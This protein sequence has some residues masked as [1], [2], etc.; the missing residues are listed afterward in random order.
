MEQSRDLGKD[1]R[2]KD[3]EDDINNYLEQG[4]KSGGK[5]I[6]GA[7]PVTRLLENGICSLCLC[8]LQ[9]AMSRTAL[10]LVF[11]PKPNPT[12]SEI[13]KKKSGVGGSDREKNI[14]MKKKTKAH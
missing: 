13:L 8:I 2:A 4:P 12:T 9:T 10:S 11:F 14:S 1:A 5:D 7:H 3:E 6:R